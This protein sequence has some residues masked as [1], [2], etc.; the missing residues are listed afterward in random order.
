[1]TTPLGAF[2]QDKLNE[3]NTGYKN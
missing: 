2:L 1:M 3:I